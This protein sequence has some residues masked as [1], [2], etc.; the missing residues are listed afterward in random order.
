[1]KSKITETR[2]SIPIFKKVVPKADSIRL[3]LIENNLQ[4]LIICGCI[5]FL[6]RCGVITI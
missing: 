1:M 5:G 6:L 4:W 2:A 3:E